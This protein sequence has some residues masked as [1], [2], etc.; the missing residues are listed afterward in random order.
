MQT[1]PAQVKSGEH[2][3]DVVITIA[4]KHVA[5]DAGDRAI[6][7][8]KT[9][10]CSFERT[11]P[12]AYR[13]R[14]EGD[15]LTLRISD[16]SRFRQALTLMREESV[17]LV[18]RPLLWIG[19][20]AIT[21]AVAVTA[22]IA[23]DTPAEAHPDSA[24]VAPVPTVPVTAAPSPTTIAEATPAYTASDLLGR[25]NEVAGS[26]HLVLDGVGMTELG[27]G[28]TVDVRDGTIVVTAEPNGDG[29]QAT[30]IVATMGLTIASI[31]P[32]ASPA[33]RA[34]V[35]ADLGLHVD[36]SNTDPL[37]GRIARGAVTYQLQ[38]RPGEHIVFSAGL[39][40]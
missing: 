36:G 7:R 18:P 16:D 35:L 30:D 8:W 12:T 25:W 33:D 19:A 39:E 6:G 32:A 3:V 5:I 22:F 4:D 17:P 27:P 40:W 37:D 20:V 26:S 31:D 29:D 9:K 10:H 21:S 1:F 14:T 23:I 13:F 38:Y 2:D 28:H 11:A 15:W 24:P 34:D